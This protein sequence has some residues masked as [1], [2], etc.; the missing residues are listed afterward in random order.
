V[1][2]LASHRRPAAR[3]LPAAHLPELGEQRAVFVFQVLAS[4]LAEQAKLLLIYCCF[5]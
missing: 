1:S 4:L 3:L 5:T 2:A